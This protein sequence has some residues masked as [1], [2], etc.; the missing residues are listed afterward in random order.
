MSGY[1]KLFS[2]I[3]TST[4]WQEDSDTKVVWVTMLALADPDGVVQASIPGLA[5]VAGVSLEACQKALNIFT[6]PDQFSRNPAY[7]GRRID[8]VEGGWQILNYELYRE[9]MSVEDRKNKAAARAQ[10]YRDRHVASR[11]VTPR[12]GGVMDSHG[13]SRQAEAEADTKESPLPPLKDPAAV[14]PPEAARYV[15]VE[16]GLAGKELLWV[17]SDVIESAGGECKETADRMVTA[18]RNYLDTE[19]GQSKYRK[20]P[21]A[22]FGDGLWRE[23]ESIQRKPA[24]S[25]KLDTG[26]LAEMKARRAAAAAGKL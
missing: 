15:L 16:L 25:N 2:S 6:S 4:I 7:E 5:H 1:T 12:H 17:V 19:E 13:E 22:F 10:R 18:Y 11:A 14:T 24:Q 3:V 26:A 21:K 8:A 23:H 20:N 9:K